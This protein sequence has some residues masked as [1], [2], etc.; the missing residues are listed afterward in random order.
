M[1]QGP[2]HC[3][4]LPLVMECVRQEMMDDVRRSANGDI[5]IREM[6]LGLCVEP[7]IRQIG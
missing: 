6:E 7:L 2:T 3:D 5:T 1:T 4:D